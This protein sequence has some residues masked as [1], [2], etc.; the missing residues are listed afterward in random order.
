M[1]PTWRFRVRR[2][3]R[4]RTDRLQRYPCVLAVNQRT[5]AA[6]RSRAT[7]SAAGDE[8]SPMPLPR[9]G[10]ARTGR[11]RTT[12]RR[13]RRK[14]HSTGRHIRRAA[15]LLSFDSAIIM[16]AALG[17][18]KR[19]RTPRCARRRARRAVKRWHAAISA[20]APPL[21]APRTTARCCTCSGSGGSASVSASRGGCREIPRYAVV[22]LATRRAVGCSICASGGY[23]ITRAACERREVQEAR[24]CVSSSA[25]RPRRGCI[26]G[27]AGGIPD[28]KANAVI[29]FLA[30]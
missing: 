26:T 24:V 19:T 7:P 16:P 17:A 10:D 11:E 4:I 8:P 6:R 3:R 15:R 30:A 20:S 14:F 2:S 25:A 5:D 22:A 21:A 29:D 12:S 13:H 1:T 9:P 28:R 27:T 23:D 18:T